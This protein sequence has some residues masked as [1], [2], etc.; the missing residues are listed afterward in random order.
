[1]SVVSPTGVHVETVYV[2]GPG[3]NTQVTDLLITRGEKI[4]A[5]RTLADHPVLDDTGRLR[6]LRDHLDRVEA[7]AASFGCP[8][9]RAALDAEAPSLNR[10]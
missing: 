8:G 2:A 9:L 10:R 7:F 1:V 5:T 6:C 3:T 4:L